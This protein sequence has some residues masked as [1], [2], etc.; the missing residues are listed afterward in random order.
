M[1][2]VMGYFNPTLRLVI[3]GEETPMTHANPML[4]K[5]RTKDGRHFIEIGL[6]DKLKNLKKIPFTKEKKDRLLAVHRLY[7]TSWTTIAKIFNDTTNN[8]L[9]NHWHVL[10]AR[11]QRK[12]K[13]KSLQ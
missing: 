2:I 6:D 4:S 8:A 11:K 10:I 3:P 1:E 13:K 5:H 9:K 7:G 12:S